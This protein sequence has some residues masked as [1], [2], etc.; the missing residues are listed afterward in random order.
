MCSSTNLSS[1][2]HSFSKSCHGSALAGDFYGTGSAFCTPLGIGSG[3]CRLRKPSAP[4]SPEQP[5]VVVNILGRFVVF[6]HGE[7]GFDFSLQGPDHKGLC[8]V[9]H[10]AH[11]IAPYMVALLIVG[12]QE[13]Y[14]SVRVLG[15]YLLAQLKTVPIWQV[16]V[17]PALNQIS[18]GGWRRLRFWHLGRRSR[19]SRLRSGY[20]PTSYSKNCRPRQL[21]SASYPHFLCFL[22]IV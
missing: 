3:A 22:Q 4:K 19:R 13:N 6:Q 21:K 8:D 1:I 20:R 7:H 10:R 18:A 5:P 2:S 15:L 9:V 12:G 11:L 17:Q 14:D 16:N